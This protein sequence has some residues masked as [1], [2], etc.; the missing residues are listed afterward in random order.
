VTNGFVEEEVVLAIQSLNRRF[1]RDGF[2]Q[3]K[4]EVIQ[5]GDLIQDCIEL[6]VKLWPSELKEVKLFLEIL[7]EEG[8]NLLPKP[9]LHLLL[10]HVLGL[11]EEG[12]L[13]LNADAVRRR[14]TSAALLTSVASKLRQS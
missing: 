4:L 2:P 9:K 10:S 12:S 1:E 3:R 14:V 13:K 11:H 6:G 5:R 7:L 8:D